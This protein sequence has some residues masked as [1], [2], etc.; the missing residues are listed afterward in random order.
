MTDETIVV[1]YTLIT[2]QK[3]KWTFGVWSEQSSYQDQANIDNRESFPH[4]ITILNWNL[5]H[6]FCISYAT[7]WDILWRCPRD[8]NYYHFPCKLIF[9][10]WFLD[11]LKSWRE[12]SQIPIVS[13]FLMTFVKVIHVIHLFLSWKSLQIKA[14]R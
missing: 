2:W 13:C 5:C 11:I 9:C 4:D 8:A 10:E 12:K 1:P 6:L 3:H 14:I 7:A